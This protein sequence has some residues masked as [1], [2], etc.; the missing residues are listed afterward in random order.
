MVRVL[1]R[2]LNSRNPENALVFR[3][4]A[5]TGCRRGEVCAIQWQDIDLNADPCGW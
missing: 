3:L 4:L 5:A 1:D 2:T